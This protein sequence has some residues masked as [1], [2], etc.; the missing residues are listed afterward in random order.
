MARLVAND[1][2]GA[3]VNEL[4]EV[5]EDP[6]V[7]H[8]GMVATTE[9][10]TLG[11]LRVTGVP[12]HLDRTPGSVRR[13]PPVFGQHNEEILAELGY[14]PGEVAALAREVAGDVRLTPAWA[15]G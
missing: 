13:S 15:K 6:Q 4:P 9:H 2:M 7:R 10:A 5:V 3:P 14:P 11:E 1:A 8:N 12:I